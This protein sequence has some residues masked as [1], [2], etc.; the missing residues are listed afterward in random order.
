M[1][2]AA[3]RA[4]RPYRRNA[5]TAGA[6]LAYDGV[7]DLAAGARRSWSEP[8]HSLT[9]RHGVRPSEEHRHYDHQNHVHGPELQQIATGDGVLE[10]SIFEAGVPPRFRLS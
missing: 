6:A 2:A 8:P 1:R 7:D 3:R 4:P 9:H 10:L 5:K